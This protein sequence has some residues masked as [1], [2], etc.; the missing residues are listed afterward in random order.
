MK[1]LFIIFTIC[2]QFFSY[3][4]ISQ[5][6]IDNCLQQIYSNNKYIC[7]A[8]QHTEAEK[9]GTL[10]GILPANPEFEMEYRK[11]AANNDYIHEFS[12][13]QAFNFPSVYFIE[14]QKNKKMKEK[15]ALDFQSEIVEILYEAQINCIELV[16]INKKREILKLRL[17][18][19]ENNKTLLERKLELGAVNILELN[20]ARIQFLNISIAS[21]ILENEYINTLLKLKELNGNLELEYNENN[22]CEFPKFDDFETL[23]AKFLALNP[24][25][26][27]TETEKQIAFLDKQLSINKNL[28]AFSIGY[29]KEIGKTET[30]NGFRFGISI[31]L[32]ENLNTIKYAKMRIAYQTEQVEAV[33]CSQ[34]AD[35]RKEYNSFLKLYEQLQLSQK[36][37]EEIDSEKLLESALIAGEISELDYYTELEFLYE[38]ID[39]T[40][41]LEWQLYITYSRLTKYFILENL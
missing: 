9:I 23:E 38:L 24:I 29:L 27:S 34:L 7:A 18:N 8:R 19:A 16:Y 10:V 12:V 5:N 22:Y 32:W 37:M 14:F 17:K 36:L 11:N 2:V 3:N 41:E 21:E 28:P 25:I 35:F 30:Y 39:N 26:K 31:P 1:K 4:A 13:N 15:I 6:Y 20:K 33:A 40:L